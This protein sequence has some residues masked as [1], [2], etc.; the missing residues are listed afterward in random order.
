[1]IMIIIKPNNLSH[2]NIA[3]LVKVILKQEE[4]HLVFLDC[5]CHSSV[6]SNFI[7][8]VQSNTTR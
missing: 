2:A 7:I 6:L 3:I 5:K 4:E 1:M 8:L